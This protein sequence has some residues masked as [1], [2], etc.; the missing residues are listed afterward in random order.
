MK[1]T[2]EVLQAAVKESISVAG[3][4]R[5]L[6]LAQAGGTHSH[7]ARRIREYQLDTSHFLGKRANR[8]PN[9]KSWKRNAWQEVLVLRHHGR[10]QKA[11]ALRRALIQSGR[12][13]RCEIPG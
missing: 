11:H 5:I 7:I 1:Y 6:G 3:V 9:H 13:Y 4:L 8:G 12:E 2:K 10:R